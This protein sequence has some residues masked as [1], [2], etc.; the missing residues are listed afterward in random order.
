MSLSLHLSLSL[1]FRGVARWRSGKAYPKDGTQVLGSPI[2]H[3]CLWILHPI[4]AYIVIVA[5]PQPS[6]SKEWLRFC[7]GR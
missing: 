2:A 4:L 3:W 7:G 6:G 5:K 1:S